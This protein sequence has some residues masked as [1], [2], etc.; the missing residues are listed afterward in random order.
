MN[1][2]LLIP[3]GLAALSWVTLVVWY[4]LRAKWWK[5][6]IGYNTM[7]VSLVIALSMTRLFFLQLTPP[8]TIYQTTE[9]VFGVF[10]YLALAFLGV[11]RIVF[12]EQSQREQQRLIALSLETG[13]NR[14]WDDPK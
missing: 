10:L 1:F 13:L 12:V 9:V 11:Q 8:Y 14:R 6:K 4:H 7:G 3:T 5:T 2:W